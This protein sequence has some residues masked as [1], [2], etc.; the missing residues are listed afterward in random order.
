MEIKY[1]LR[2]LLKWWWLLIIAA[3][4]AAFA[5]YMV[6]RQQPLIY[7]SNTTLVAGS[8]IFESNPSSNELYLNQQLATFY[9]ELAKR[10]PVRSATM[11]ALSITFLPAYN[12]RLIPNSQFIEILVSDTDPLRA[13][14]VANELANQL[15]Q[16]T[17]SYTEESQVR[18]DFIDEQL[19][20]LEARITETQDEINEQQ[21][22]LADLTGARAI[23]DA[24]TE[25]ANLERRLSD[26]TTDY[27]N[28]LAN[29]D[30]GA[31]NTLT[32]I[33]PANLPR[34]PVGPNK[35]LMVL[36][37]A[38]AALG[39]AAAAA[40]LLEYL[41]DTLK[42]P[43]EIS[44]L[45]GLPVIGYIADIVKEDYLGA[46]VAKHPR[47][48]VAE[49]F[50]SLRTDLE[51]AGVD[52]PLETILVASPGM[53]VGKT[54]VAINLALVIAQS[55][56]KV[57]LVDA[58]LRKPSVHRILG[59]SNHRGLSDIFRGN[60]E[61]QHV[62]TNWKDGNL[63]VVT[64]GGQPPN[65]AEL[66]SSKKMN[67]VIQTLK[68]MAD[69]VVVDG[70]PFLVTD[71]T[72]LSAKVDGVVLV[73]RYGHTRRNEALNT[74]NQLRRVDARVLGVVL[75]RIPRTREDVFGMYNYYY[76]EYYAHEGEDVAPSV[77][78]RSWFSRI[79]RRKVEPVLESVEAEDPT[80]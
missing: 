10:E 4:L 33:D 31:V 23:A 27:A 8:A 75:N 79:F 35:N 72:I 28:L 39:I 57:V 6:V 44:R 37:S 64:S 38:A 65:P 9:V 55:G 30:R 12:I 74:I 70:P 34:T 50:R 1:I 26:L 15:I 78:G 43:D 41:D 48:A 46:Y 7:Q 18:D 51:F 22:R 3:L 59:L 76:R 61:V 17:P 53:S 69:V 62:T 14:A 54:S 20:R 24:E 73:Y 52:K 2:P 58:D 56:K 21:A 63:T 67:Q 11:E 45:V 80:T 36:L 66:L 40:Y 29:S 16:L 71:A 25:I 42:M 77:N 13:Q 19:V 60:L 5:S 68:G 32:V 47:S 49:A